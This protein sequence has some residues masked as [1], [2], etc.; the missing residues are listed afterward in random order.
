M[1]AWFV[2]EQAA[3][4]HSCPAGWS[5]FEASCHAV[6]DTPA[7]HDEAVASCREQGATLVDIQSAAENAHVQDLCDQ[8]ACWVGLT[9]PP[10]SEEW[11]WGDGTTAGSRGEW[12][13]YTNWDD[14]EPN[15]HGG[16]DEDATFMNYW[17][18][19]GMSAPQSPSDI[20]RYLGKWYDGGREMPAWY[21][22]ER[23]AEA[24]SCTGDGWVAY[25][26]S[27]YRVSEDLQSYPVASELCGLDGAQLVRI[28]S[29]EENTHVQEM[30][31]HRTCWIGL[32]EP[33]DSE[34]WLWED[35]THLGRKGEWS[36]YTNWDHDEPNNWGGTDED[37]T[38]MNLWLHLDRPAPSKVKCWNELK[39]IAGFLNLSL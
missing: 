4:G 12:S 9:E 18:H 2:C 8:R 24:G 32:A 16:R 21:V 38:F 37:A 39:K 25:G 6:S 13:G 27:C 15:N 7:W 30:C 33:M 35:G 28:E 5:R 11:I 23:A 26:D 22:C 29:P 1:S 34:E 14:G 36:G 17:G 19:F 3:D 10:D 31:G 20:Q